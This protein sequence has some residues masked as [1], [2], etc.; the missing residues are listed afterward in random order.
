VQGTHT[1]GEHEP[2]L[3]MSQTT[4]EAGR[5]LQSG[6]DSLPCRYGFPSFKEAQW[7]QGVRFGSG[8]SWACLRLW[9]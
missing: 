3:S 4:L 7:S 9:H 6:M 8:F 2:R 5:S 1:C